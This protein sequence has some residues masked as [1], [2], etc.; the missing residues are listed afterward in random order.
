MK[1]IRTNRILQYLFLVI[2]LLQFVLK[3][4]EPFDW[5]VLLSDIFPRGPAVPAA[6]SKKA[7]DLNNAGQEKEEK[8]EEEG[9]HQKNGNEKEEQKEKEESKDKR[10][11]S[12]RAFT[13]RNTDAEITARAHFH[14]AALFPE[15]AV[16]EVIAPPPEKA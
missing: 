2:W 6:E 10:G 13:L 4:G 12:W 3:E 1:L 15:S 9:K 5:R 11:H 7:F 16:R 14:H 8:E